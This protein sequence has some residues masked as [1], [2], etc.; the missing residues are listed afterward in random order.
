MHLGIMVYH[1][2]QHISSW[3]L[4]EA[5]PGSSSENLKQQVWIAQTAERKFD[6]VFLAD[7]LST[8]P[9]YHSSTIVRLEPVTLLSALAIATTHIGLAASATTTYA[10]PYNMAR[11][12]G[13]LDHISGGRAA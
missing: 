7:A 10:E 12:L 5:E 2:G 4:R 3:R 1:T 13:S 6:M 11:L 8:S 9:N